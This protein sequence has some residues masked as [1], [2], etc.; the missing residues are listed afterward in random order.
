MLHTWVLMLANLFRESFHL[1]FVE[2]GTSASTTD[3]RR[4]CRPIG[5]RLR[6]CEL[7]RGHSQPNSEREIEHVACTRVAARDCGR[8][9]GWCGEKRW[10]ATQQQTTK[11]NKMASVVRAK[12]RS[13]AGTPVSAPQCESCARSVSRREKR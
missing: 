10:G 3:E 2:P 8:D 1:I 5:V 6:K 13:E 7:D 12:T 9:D 4:T 11:V